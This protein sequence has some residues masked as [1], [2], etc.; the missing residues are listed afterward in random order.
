MI[1]KN[2]TAKLIALLAIGTLS[3][4]VAFAQVAP[5]SNFG[6]PDWSRGTGIAGLISSI[7]LFILGIA[8]AVAVLF[9]VIGG[10]QYILSGANEDLAKRG[11]TTVV[12]AVVGLII[13]ILSY[14]VITVVYRTL[15]SP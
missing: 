6:L 13:I 3:A 5:P 9:I 10:F 2:K 7:I 8:G 4:P 12:N 14:T 1:M 15:V 11:R